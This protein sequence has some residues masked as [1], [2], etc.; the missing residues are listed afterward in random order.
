MS[1]SKFVTKI[2]FLI[3]LQRS[4]SLAGSPPPPPP[5]GGEDY[6]AFYKSYEDDES[7]DKDNYSSYFYKSYED[8]KSENTS[9]NGGDYAGS[10]PESCLPKMSK[11]KCL[12]RGKGNTDYKSIKWI[13]KNGCMTCWVE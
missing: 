10:G 12:S 2:W 3:N 1:K 8:D 7:G 5:S 11:E 6:D 4:F 13:L 9:I